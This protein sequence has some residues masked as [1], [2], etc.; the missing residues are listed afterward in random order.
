[1]KAQGAVILVVT[2]ICLAQEPE[3]REHWE[4]FKE[5]ALPPHE[6]LVGADLD[7]EVL[8]SSRPDHGD[9]RLRDADGRETPYAL[10]I[11]RELDRRDELRVQEFDRAVRGSTAEVRIDLGD[12][13][14]SHNEVEVISSGE[15]FRRRVRIFASDDRREWA[16]LAEPW[17]LFRFQSG[18]VEVHEARIRYPESRRRFLRAEVEADPEI[19]EAAPEIEAVTVRLAVESPAR[20]S[21]FALPVPKREPTR[22]DGRTASQY[23]VDLDGKLPVRG[24]K[25]GIEGNFSRPYRLEAA[26]EPRPRTVAMGRLAREADADKPFVVVE[27]EETST[28]RLVLTVTDDRNAPLEFRELRLLVAAREVLF[29]PAHGRA[30]FRLEFGNPAAL[31]PHY[32]FDASAPPAAAGV[33][34]AELGPR[35]LNPGYRPDQPLTERAPWLIHTALGTACLILFVILRRIASVQEG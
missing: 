28:E 7:R 4:H 23:V 34:R 9:V 1:M 5:V 14:R 26:V 17:F 15:A 6:G 2:G 3:A 13:P 29:D 19:D 21:E 10:R 31:P 8:V 25:L 30:P 27:L 20:N 11:R 12:A 18:S 33:P 24:L 16:L 22:N 32:D 35:Q